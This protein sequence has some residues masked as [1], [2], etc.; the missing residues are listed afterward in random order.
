MSGPARRRTRFTSSGEQT[1]PLMPLA[2]AFFTR[3]STR[4]A[5]G[6][7]VAKIGQIF[8]IETRKNRHS[9][10]F[11]GRIAPSF[12]GRLHHGPAAMHGEKRRCGAGKFAAWRVSL[13]R[14]YRKA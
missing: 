6:R 8:L 1:I 2:R 7:W 3:K 10:K 14:R 13:F 9:Q 12:D 11:G 4:S 5:I